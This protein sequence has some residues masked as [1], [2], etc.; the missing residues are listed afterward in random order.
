MKKKGKLHVS[1]RQLILIKQLIRAGKVG[2]RMVKRLKVVELASEGISNYQI[3]K[4]IDLQKNMVGIWRKRWAAKVNNLTRLEMK[5][6][7]SDS[8]LRK[9]ILNCL[10]DEPRSGSP[11]RITLSQKNQIVALACEKPE[12]HGVPIS[13]W[14]LSLLTSVV[15][16]KN[17]VKEISRSTVGEIIKKNF[18]PIV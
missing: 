11:A 6:K 16:E 14:N 18:N 7:L 15:K 8:D 10:S 12:D 4:L 2:P 13:Q 1:E 17:I 3:N 5:H 9:Q